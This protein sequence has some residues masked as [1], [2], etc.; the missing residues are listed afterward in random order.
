MVSSRCM[1]PVH[2]NCMP[3]NGSFGIG[4]TRKIYADPFFNNTRMTNNDGYNP[5]KWVSRVERV[6]SKS[7]H[8]RSGKGIPRNKNSQKYQD[9]IQQKANRLYEKFT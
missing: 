1:H 3:Q 5:P 8:G 9:F 7:G 2:P 4:R 6:A